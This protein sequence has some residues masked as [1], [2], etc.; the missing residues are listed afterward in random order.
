[1][2]STVVESHRNEAGSRQRYVMASLEDYWLL[3][4]QQCKPEQLL[5]AAVLLVPRGLVQLIAEVLALNLKA[6]SLHF[7]GI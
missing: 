3:H 4:P 7:I 1:M 2:V 5:E 6:S